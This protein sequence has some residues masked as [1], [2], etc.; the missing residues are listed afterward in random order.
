MTMNDTDTSQITAIVE[1]SEQRIIA[2][3]DKRISELDKRVD[4]I[5]QTQTL[6]TE[7][8]QKQ[9]QKMLTHQQETANRMIVLEERHTNYETLLASTQKINEQHQHTLDQLTRNQN[10]IIRTHTQ[11]ETLLQTIQALLNREIE[12]VGQLRTATREAHEEAIAASVS[13]AE[14]RSGVRANQMDIIEVKTEMSQYRKPV[15]FVEDLQRLMDALFGSWRSRIVTAIATLLGLAL[16]GAYVNTVI[17]TDS[18][19][20]LFRLFTFGG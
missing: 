9:N 2:H 5:E 17:S 11:F 16:L 12:E 6:E 19:E 14:L 18:L 13:E 8:R 15:E 20:N 7:R 1:A 10:D 4:D 3:V